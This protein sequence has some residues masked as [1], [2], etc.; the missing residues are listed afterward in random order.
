MLLSWERPHEGEAQSL[1]SAV[2][3]LRIVVVSTGYRNWHAFRVN[4]ARW[5]T[6]TAIGNGGEKSCTKSY[7]ICWWNV[8]WFRDDI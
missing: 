6:G 8:Q 7:N 1:P 2:V 3:H 5:V 4:C